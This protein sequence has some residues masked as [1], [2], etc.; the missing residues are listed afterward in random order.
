MA[1]RIFS[2][3]A[4]PSPLRGRKAT[5]VPLGWP[6][7]TAWL[8]ACPFVLRPLVVDRHPQTSLGGGTGIIRVG[9]ERSSG[10]GTGMTCAMREGSE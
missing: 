10:V 2:E 6:G 1:L 7:G 3:I 9:S 4:R 8:Q 5:G